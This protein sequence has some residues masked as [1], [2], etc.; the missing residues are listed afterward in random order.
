MIN[1][2]QKPEF[3]KPP[4]KLKAKVG[5]G[6]IAPERIKNAQNYINNNTVDF[7]PYANTFIDLVKE[8]T[9]KAKKSRD[10][11][12]RDELSDPI[13]QLKANGGMFK[14]PLISD[15]ADICLKFVEVI[16]EM[17]DDAYVVIMAHVRTIEIITNKHMT[18]NGGA[19]GQALIKELQQVC[20][21]YLSRYLAEKEK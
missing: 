15:V 1:T 2:A 16:E 11:Y 18:G 5:A 19:E 6:G 12:N 10:H 9:E 17:N 8:L 7:L 3:I 4:N 20:T 13:M 21:R 14:Y